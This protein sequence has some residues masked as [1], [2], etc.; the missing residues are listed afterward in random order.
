MAILENIK[1][2]FDGFMNA[3]SGAGTTRDV[4]YYDAFTS[5]GRLNRTYI[6][7]MYAESAVFAKIIDLYPQTA[8]S[9]WVSFNHDQVE[10]INQ[11]IKDLKLVD[12]LIKAGIK[13]RKDGGWVIFCDA[14]D[15]QESDTPLNLDRV[16]SFNAM[17]E[18]EGR[19]VNPMNPN[20]A[21]KPKEGLYTIDNG[22]EQ[23]VVHESRLLIFDGI[24]VSDDYRVGG[25]GVCGGTVSKRIHKSVARYELGQQNISSLSSK[26]LIGVWKMF[27]L[28]DELEAS[29]E[30]DAQLK[31]RFRAKTLGV[32]QIHD[33]VIDSQDDYELLTPNL[34]GIDKIIDPTE[35]NLVTVSGIPHTTLLGETSG[36]L[37][38]TGESQKRDWH[39]TIAN[40][41][42]AKY[43]DPIRKA[44]DMITAALNV[45]PVGEFNFP[46]LDV[47]TEKEQSET[48]LNVA[49]ADDLNINNQI[50]EPE[51]CRER[52]RDKFTV[53]FELD[54][55]LYKPEI[56]TTPINDEQ[57][58]A[59]A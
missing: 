21:G 27:G 30:N 44:L 23:K 34:N 9:Q 31:A 5:S 52:Y 8:L 32:S 19:Y 41:Q 39:K 53:D 59:A 22:S 46:P 11:K 10:K 45:E 17:L 47:P 24:E 54:D 36:G 37:G 18:F 3:I 50:Y 12:Y 29:D 2:R 55:S 13:D 40:Y 49:R 26:V 4:G 1:K 56:D 7:A 25:E 48:R 6:D 16:K 57:K 15:G 35:R 38:S 58:S 20:R 33:V 51:E 14:N 42:R 28:N 43:A